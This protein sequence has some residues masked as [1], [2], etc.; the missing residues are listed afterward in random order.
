MRDTSPSSSQGM[1]RALAFPLVLLAVIPA[2]PALQ[3]LG[4][5][6][7]PWIF[8]AAAAAIGVLADLVRRATE[9]LALKVGPTIGGL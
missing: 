2:A 7:A 5:V 3:Y 6:A 9:Q 8:V 4:H 1:F